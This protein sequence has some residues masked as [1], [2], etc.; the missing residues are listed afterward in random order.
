MKEQ[1]QDGAKNI[2]VVGELP[3]IYDTTDPSVQEMLKHSREVETSN[4]TVAIKLLEGA[5]S[6]KK[7]K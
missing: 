1:E 3:F 4:S 6:K 5:R 7:K 2:M